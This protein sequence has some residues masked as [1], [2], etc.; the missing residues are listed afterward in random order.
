MSTVFS[1]LKHSNHPLASS[2][3]KNHN[4]Q[5]TDQIYSSHF[6]EHDTLRTT[7][8]DSEFDFDLSDIIK[9]TINI[10]KQEQSVPMKA[11]CNIKDPCGICFKSVN[12]NQK[13][14][15]CNT[16]LK[17]IHRKCNGISVK[18]YEA[19]VNEPDE[20]P[21][22]CIL[23]TNDDMASK[24]P[25]GYLSKIELSELYGVELPSQLE[26][27]LSFEIRSKLSQIPNLDDYD[28]DENFVQS[29]NSK[30][31]DQ[32][33]SNKLTCTLSKSLSL[34]HINIRSLS[35][36][37]NEFK[38]VLSMSKVKFDVAGITESK[39]Q[40][41]KDFIVNVD[42]NGY[43]MYKQPSESASGGVVIYVN[44]ELNYSRLEE[45]SVTENDF[46]SLWI[47]I[48]NQKQ[49]NIICRCIYRHPNTDP[50]KFLEYIES[51]I[52]KIDCNK[53]EIFFM[54]DLNIDLLQ[55]DNNVISNDFINSMTAHSFLP[56]ILQPIPELLTTLHQSLIIFFPTLLIVNESVAIELHSCQIIL[57]NSKNI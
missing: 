5:K 35:K 36:H 8:I 27:L 24:F 53:Y 46:E 33:A 1:T 52:S 21:W 11:C 32:L 48:S 25:F 3:R 40:I 30:Y 49:E 34:M 37:I 54:E 12:K 10:A 47:E 22:L 55:Y 15:K 19:L 9:R 26:L 31:M 39:Q 38:T 13:A 23:C 2:N 51:T 50:T 41:G 42:I 14:M 7:S 4:K 44:D 45:F 6:N 28:I 57:S 17:W 16:C 56:Y 29:I 18:E 43:H 20:I